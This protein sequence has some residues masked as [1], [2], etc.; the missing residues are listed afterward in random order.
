MQWSN[1]LMPC[2]FTGP[3]MFC[4]GPYFLTKLK[5]LTAFSATSK[6]FVP[7]QKP[8]L[9]NANHLS[10]W[11]K[12]F[13]DCHNIKIKHFGTCERTR[14]QASS[15]WIKHKVVQIWIPMVARCAYLME[16]VIYILLTSSNNQISEFWI[17]NIYHEIFVLI[18]LMIL[19][20]HFE[21]SLRFRKN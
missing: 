6:T 14:H 2:P 20:T 1:V 5:N 15:E 21:A 9:L 17:S 8:I 7:A 13:C 16:I 18:F 19:R 3:K 10:V 4:A 11:H 12:N